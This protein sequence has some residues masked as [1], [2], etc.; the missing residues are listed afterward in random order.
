MERIRQLQ[1]GI[2]VSPRFFSY[3]GYKT[4]EGD[5]NLPKEVQTNWAELYNNCR[6]WMVFY[7]SSI[8]ISCLRFKSIDSL[9]F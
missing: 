9:Y 1:S 3:G 2:V 7:K 6:Q 8:E 5:K 4:L